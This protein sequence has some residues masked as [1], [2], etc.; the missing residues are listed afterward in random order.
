MF[1]FVGLT[2]NYPPLQLYLKMRPSSSSTIFCLSKRFVSLLYKRT[3]HSTMTTH[4][5]H[6]CQQGAVVVQQRKISIPNSHGEMLVGI[7]H[8]TGSKELVILCHGLG[9]T[10]EET[11]MLNLTSALTREG[12]SAFR[13]DFAGNG[14]SEGSFQLR[15]Y[16]RE[17]DD[18]RDVV[19]YYFQEGREVSAI[20]GHSKG[21]NVVLLYASLH[22]DI[23]TVI[24]LAGRFNLERGM[25]GLL[26]KDVIERIKKDGYIDVPNEAGKVVF[27]LTEEMLMERLT[28]DMHAASLS[29]DKECRVL[30]VHSSTDESVPL[31]D[32][33]EFAKLIPNHKLRIIEG[34]N[35]VFTSHQD[36]LASIVLDFIK[37]GLQQCKHRPNQVL[38]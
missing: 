34:A 7:L 6:S 16:Q 29:I 19:I 38:S 14:E 33:L 1:R 5:S 22:R 15:N 27:R 30:T 21:G 12:V 37:S 9:A 28:T 11:N 31:E 20:L 3:I 17:A 13:F 8:E 18:L 23:R 24:N 25:E 10:K 2:P 36:E 32:A 26:S 35:H 4:E